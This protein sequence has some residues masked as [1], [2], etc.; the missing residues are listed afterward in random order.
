MPWWRYCLVALAGI[1]AHA[2][3]SKASDGLQQP[4]AAGRKS[5]SKPNIVFI[6]TDDQDLHMDSLSYMPFLKTHL[7][8]EG[9][10]FQRHYCTI[11]LCCPSRVSLWTGRAA[12]NT[13]VTDVNPPYGRCAMSK[14]CSSRLTLQVVTQSLLARA[15]MKHGSLSGSRMPATTHTIPGNY[16][17]LTH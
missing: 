5:S 1:T 11:A 9:T 12:H 14:M 2:A 15:S 3:V 7:I 13:N 6:L 17:T 10:F 16:S 8:D 4:L